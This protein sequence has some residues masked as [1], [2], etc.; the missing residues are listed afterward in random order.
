MTGVERWIPDVARFAQLAI[1]STDLDPTYPVLR[2]VH[3]GRG[4]NVEQE[5]WSSVCFVGYYRL[6]SS[7]QCSLDPS[8]PNARTLRLGTGVER[9]TLRTPEKM[10]RHWLSVAT[11]IDMHGSLADWLLEG[12][13][14]DPYENWKR[15]RENYG[16]AWG[17]GRWA[18]YKLAEVLREVNGFKLAPPDMGNDG[19]TGPIA[20]LHMLYGPPTPR[21]RPD[22]IRLYDAQGLDLKIRLGNEGV[23][24]NLAQ[25]ETVLCDFH[26]LVTGHY[27]VG[28]DID[29]MLADLRRAEVPEPIRSEVLAARR[30]S[31]PH[32]YLGELR[33]WSGVDKQRRWHYRVTGEV[34]AR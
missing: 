30:V 33:G 2:A 24:A 16:R 11:L 31:I 34:L 20:G 28:H 1:A 21:P 9:R 15:L 19:S 3:R 18:T 7:L 13:G 29:V 4:L 25:V 5:L 14:P 32:D 17:N 8:I 10:R 26:N 27:Y 23:L 12:F 6:A 22:L